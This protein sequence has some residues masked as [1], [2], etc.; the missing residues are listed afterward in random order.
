[1]IHQTF[2]LQYMKDVVLARLLDEQTFGAFNSLIF[3]NNVEIAM[4]LG[5]DQRFCC[6][7]FDMLRDQS[8][9]MESQV[10]LANFVDQFMSLCKQYRQKREWV[11]PN[12]YV[13]T[14]CCVY[15]C[16]AVKMSIFTGYSSPWLIWGCLRCLGGF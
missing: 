6:D 12:V 10:D 4:G 9:P 15:V 8:L 5:L 14:L 3:F 2:R 13:L 16:V 1:M 7:L 11:K